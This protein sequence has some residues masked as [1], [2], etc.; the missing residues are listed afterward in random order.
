[1]AEQR[2]NQEQILWRITLLNKHLEMK[3]DP[4]YHSLKEMKDAN[5]NEKLFSAF[6]NLEDSFIFDTPCSWTIY[7]IYTVSYKDLK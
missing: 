2:N 6:G 1:M 3:S 5:V 7:R 4:F